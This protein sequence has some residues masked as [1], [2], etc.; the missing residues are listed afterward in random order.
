[1]PV[2]L[3]ETAFFFFDDPAGLSKL[4]LEGGK[5]FRQ[6]GVRDVQTGIL[7]LKTQGLNTCQPDKS[8]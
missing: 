4:G 6:H 8:E 1:M 5:G 7:N 2:E 3:G